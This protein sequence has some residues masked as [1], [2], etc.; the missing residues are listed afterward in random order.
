M[1]FGTTRSNIGAMWCVESKFI[2]YR[3]KY[4]LK[5]WKP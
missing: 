4:W 3:G 2:V 5:L 1:E